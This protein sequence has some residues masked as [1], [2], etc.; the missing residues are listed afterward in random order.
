[1]HDGNIHALFHQ[2][3]GRFQ[4]QQAAA[5]DNRL[6][7]C[8]F[9]GGQHGVDV[10]DIAKGNHTRHIMTG[11]RN[12]KRA[13]TGSDN[14]AVILCFRAIGRAHDALCAIDRVDPFALVQ[15]D[16]V[17]FIPLFIVEHDFVN[18]FFPG[19]HRRQ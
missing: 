6:A 3:V 8:L 9:R 11:H 18:G 19:Q 12:D 13:G 2:T 16:A 7:A 1:M 14:Q 5:D 15:D 17:I 10:V 4:A